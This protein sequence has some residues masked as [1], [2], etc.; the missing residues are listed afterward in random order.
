MQQLFTLKCFEL[1]Q[2]PKDQMDFNIEFLDIHMN[3][4]KY[5]YHDF[6]WKNINIFDFEWSLIIFDAPFGLFN[7][8]GPIG[9]YGKGVR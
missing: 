8:F 1:K 2:K 4:K 5:I 9:E 6:K 7:V 3:N